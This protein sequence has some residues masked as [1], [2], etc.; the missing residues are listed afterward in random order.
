MI[1]TQIEAGHAYRLQQ[2]L[3][4]RDGKTGTLRAIFRKGTVVTVKRLEA[5][6]DHAFFEGLSVPVPL[7]SLARMVTPA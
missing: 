5:D 3:E 1:G 2:D 4:V 6:E 7:A